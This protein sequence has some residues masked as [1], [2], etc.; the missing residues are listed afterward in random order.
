MKEGDINMELSAISRQVGT[1]VLMGVPAIVG[2]GII[3]FIFGNFTALIVYE[4]LLAFT[5]LGFI[6]K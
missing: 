6:S 1:M 4:V 5:S 3:Y 2:G